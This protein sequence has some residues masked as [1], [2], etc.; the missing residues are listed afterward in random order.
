VKLL[1]AAGRRL[2]DLRN[3][4]LLAVAYTTMCR[5]SE[6]VALVAEDLRI[7]SCR[8][9]VKDG[10]DQHRRPVAITAEAVAAGEKPA[11]LARRRH[12]D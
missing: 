4:A 12:A 6:L 2:V 10:P 5:R 1:S 7:D 9:E 3:K 8:L 11:A